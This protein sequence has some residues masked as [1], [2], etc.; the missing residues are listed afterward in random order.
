MKMERRKI[1]LYFFLLANDSL[2]LLTWIAELTLWKGKQQIDLHHT[3]LSQC[4]ICDSQNLSKVQSADL[5][6]D[7]IRKVAPFVLSK[8]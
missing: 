7:V 8:L 2:L 3:Y 1:T 4:R 5:T 6:C